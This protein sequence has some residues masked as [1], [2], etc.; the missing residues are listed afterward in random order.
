M[1]RIGKAL[2]DPAG[3]D[4]A[5]YETT[6]SAESGGGSSTHLH[7]YYNSG[8][9]TTLVLANEAIAE[10]ILKYIMSF[11]SEIYEMDGV[12]FGA[13]VPVKET[14]KSDSSVIEVD[15][16]KNKKN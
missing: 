1:I 8:S 6:D 14:P 13:S 3:I 7:L 9:I 10:E 4:F 11:K 12:V 16:G 15:F 5:T 2:I